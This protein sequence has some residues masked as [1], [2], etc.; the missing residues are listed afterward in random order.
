MLSDTRRRRGR[1]SMTSLIDVIFLL[2]LFFMLTS[3]FSRYSELELSAAGGNAAPGSAAEVATVFLSLSEDR[4]LVNGQ[5][6]ELGALAGNVKVT[7]AEKPT[8]LLISAGKDVTSQ[9]LVDVLSVLN[10]L[11]GLPGLSITVLG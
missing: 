6:T 7:A 11:A 1:V 4:L 2:L 10:A 5:P 8:R 3:T 9:R